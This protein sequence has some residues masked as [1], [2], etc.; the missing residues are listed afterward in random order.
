M[1]ERASCATSLRASSAMNS[2]PP[3]ELPPPA[4]H[5][6]P[7]A[8]PVSC[9]VLHSVVWCGVVC[10][11]LALP[12]LPS[13]LSD[14]LRL[15]GDTHTT[16]HNTEAASGSALLDSTER[17]LRGIA[18]TLVDSRMPLNCT[19]PRPPAQRAAL[20]LQLHAHFPGALSEAEWADD[21][22]LWA[23][24]S[25]SGQRFAFYLARQSTGL[26]VTQVAKVTTG[27]SDSDTVVR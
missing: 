27:S 9:S 23:S 12:V 19:V 24:L 22:C 11:C 25:A 7:R 21:H 8:P 4:S 15:C 5:K 1:L 20:R 14:L 26:R 2:T 16:Q 3:S 18:S 6:H 10:S 17:Y 13:L